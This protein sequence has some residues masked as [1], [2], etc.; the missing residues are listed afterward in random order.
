MKKVV[1]IVLLLLAA[2]Y[3]LARFV[4]LEPVETRPGLSLSG[5]PAA[6]IPEVWTGMQQVMLETRSWY[7]IRHSITVVAWNDGE[8]LYIPCR[9][10]AKKRWPRNVMADP[11]V[12]VKI[13][14]SVY[15]RT[16][17]RLDDE[18]FKAQ[19]TGHDMPPSTWL[20]VLA[21]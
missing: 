8:R 5:N 9:E 1:G 17:Q 4:P 21:E 12:R 20:W 15:E 2:V 10:C 13:G 19:L 11:R 3:L 7:G 14:D 6:G 16:M 18:S